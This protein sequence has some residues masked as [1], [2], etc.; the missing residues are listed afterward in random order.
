ML[1]CSVMCHSLQPHG[2]QHARLL[3]PSPTPIELCL[4]RFLYCKTS[5]RE[6]HMCL[7]YCR[8]LSAYYVSD[9][10]WMLTEHCLKEIH[11]FQEVSRSRIL[12][13]TGLKELL[14]LQAAPKTRHHQSITAF[15][16][17]QSIYTQALDLLLQTPGCSLA[18]SPPPF[19]M[20][21]HLESSVWINH[22][23]H[24]LRRQSKTET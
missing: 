24:G 18:R 20:Y 9:T 2:L 23:T 3:C 16:P 10:L 14:L 7:M 21:S 6:G 5:W 13:G 15:L 4:S 8:F 19:P 22:F 11:H 1:S 17:V 12:A